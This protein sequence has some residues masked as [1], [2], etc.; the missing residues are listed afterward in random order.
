MRAAAVRIVQVPTSRRAARDRASE[1]IKRLAGLDDA[2]ILLME[3]DAYTTPEVVS[4][5]HKKSKEVII[6]RFEPAVLLVQR[7]AYPVLF[8]ASSE[9]AMSRT[10]LLTELNLIMEMARREDLTSGPYIYSIQV[11][12]PRLLENVL[13]FD[14]LA[15]HF[16]GEVPSDIRSGYFYWSLLY[17]SPIFLRGVLLDKILAHAREVEIALKNPSTNLVE[18]KTVRLG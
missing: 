4:R 7:P 1:K 10:E 15:D 12:E 2:T 11:L 8:S 14:T 6:R 17:D 18:R 3:A 16:D 9:I 13:D 5:A